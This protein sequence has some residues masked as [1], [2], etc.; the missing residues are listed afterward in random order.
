MLL[1]ETLPFVSEWLEDEDEGVERSVQRLVR[2]IE[3]LSGEK[4]DRYL[5]G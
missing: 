2:V 5:E 3:E 1:P 4:L